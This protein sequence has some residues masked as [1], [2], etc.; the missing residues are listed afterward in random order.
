MPA[1]QSIADTILV[2]L[3]AAAVI[4]TANVNG[5]TL[6]MSGWDGCLFVFNV[7]AMV[8]T[9]T[10]DARIVSSAN[11]NMSGNANIANAA[12]TQ[13]LAATGG[14]NSYMIDVWRPT[15]RYI[16]SALVPATANVTVGSIAIRYH[17]GGILPVTQTAL[18][19][20]K[21]AQN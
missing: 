8:A 13:V 16:R 12:L 11:S 10:F 4:G 21:V 2:T 1:H 20:V 18:Q 5:P 9:A 3:D 19:T 14:S 7:G 17:A 15:N 6:D